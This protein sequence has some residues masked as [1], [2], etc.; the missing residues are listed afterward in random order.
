MNDKGMSRLFDIIKR[1]GKIAVAKG[2]NPRLH[3]TQVAMIATEVGE[4]L[5]ELY[6][7]MTCDSSLRQFI[8]AIKEASF[9]FENHRANTQIRVKHV[10]DSEVVDKDALLRELSDICIRVFTYVSG[11]NLTDEFVCTLHS[12]IDANELRPH[13]HNKRF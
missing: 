4:A 12:V 11:N 6:T 5:E 7:P 3:A 2:F 13:K 1:C 9:K 10:D 8:D